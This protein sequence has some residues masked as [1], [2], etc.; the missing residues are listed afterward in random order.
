MLPSWHFFQHQS[1]GD[2]FFLL[3]YQLKSRPL[4]KPIKNINNNHVFFF[5]FHEVKYSHSSRPWC[6]KRDTLGTTAHT[7]LRQQHW[8]PNGFSKQELSDRNLFT[9]PSTAHVWNCDR[10]GGRD[11]TPKVNLLWPDEDVFGH[12]AGAQTGLSFTPFFEQT[13]CNLWEALWKRRKTQLG[14]WP[15]GDQCCRWLLSL[16]HIQRT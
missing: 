5:F 12:E 11:N 2:C 9:C 13:V 4:L 6:I 16:S 14:R 15:E 10:Q 8:G 1:A 7:D 3:R